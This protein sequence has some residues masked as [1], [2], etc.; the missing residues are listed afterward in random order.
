MPYPDEITEARDWE[1]KKKSLF[2]HREVNQLRNLAQRAC[3]G[4]YHQ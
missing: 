2:I 4:H 3:K 1:N